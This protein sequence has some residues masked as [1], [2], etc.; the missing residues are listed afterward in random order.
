VDTPPD[1][2]PPQTTH[3]VGPGNTALPEPKHH[4]LTQIYGPLEFSSG[5]LYTYKCHTVK[6]VGC[7]GTDIAM[8][9]DTPMSIPGYFLMMVV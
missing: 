9:H 3:W 4:K 5:R 1:G 7:M 8:Q 6:G 2:S